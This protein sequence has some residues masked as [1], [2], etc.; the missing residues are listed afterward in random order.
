MLL[1]DTNVAIYA[2]GA[3]H[4]LKEGSHRI[5]TQIAKGEIRANIDVETLQE[6]LHVYGARNER[7]KGFDTL[8]DLLLIFPNP[9]PIGREEIEE[10]RDLIRQY[11][12]LVARD[13][14]HAAVV[15]IHALDGII[16]ADKAFDRIKGLNRSGIA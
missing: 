7:R 4:P 1:V 11:H 14:I 5:L 3:A 15:R 9:I 2:A 6:I 10:A 8:D 13:A 16:S 12:F